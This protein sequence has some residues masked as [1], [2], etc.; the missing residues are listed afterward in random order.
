MFYSHRSQSLLLC[1]IDDAELTLSGQSTTGDSHGLV[2]ILNFYEM[3]GFSIEMFG[4][5]SDNVRFLLKML[6]FAGLHRE[7]WK[8]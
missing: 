4:F 3:L 6:Y 5:C 2:N 1:S 7:L 8:A